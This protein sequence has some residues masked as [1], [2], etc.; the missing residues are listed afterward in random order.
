MASNWLMFPFVWHKYRRGITKLHWILVS[1]SALWAHAGWLMWLEGVLTIFHRLLSLLHYSK[2]SIM[3]WLLLGLCKDCEIVY[4]VPDSRPV[5]TGIMCRERSVQ[6]HIKTQI[7][8][9]LSHLYQLLQLFILR[10]F[11]QS[12]AVKLPSSVQNFKMF[13]QLNLLL[14][15]DKF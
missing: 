10:N 14:W 5:I 15:W 1:R 3:I 7:F 11:A 9:N 2:R 13:R 6:N 8:Q 4:S 12:T